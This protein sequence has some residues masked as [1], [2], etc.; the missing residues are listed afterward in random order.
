MRV[1]LGEGLR[2]LH[3]LDIKVVSSSTTIAEVTEEIRN[4]I[5][6]AIGHN[7][8]VARMLIRPHN[9]GAEQLT[10]EDDSADLADH[11][12]LEDIGTNELDL[13]LRRTN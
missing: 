8:P 2:H 13:I 1:H 10:V 12:T 9:D 3:T 5:Y 11:L 4:Q 6:D 7:I